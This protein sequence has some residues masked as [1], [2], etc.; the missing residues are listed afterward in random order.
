MCRSSLSVYSRAC[1]R[2]WL[3]FAG[4]ALLRA[5]SLISFN[6][7]LIHTPPLATPAARWLP[8][9]FVGTHD[10]LEHH[11]RLTTKYAAPTLCLDRIIEH[12]CAAFG[13]EKPHWPGPAPRKVA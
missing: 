6:N 4:L 7:I 8:W 10:H 2:V 5:V 12:A 11:A 1:V 9:I 3:A 13:V